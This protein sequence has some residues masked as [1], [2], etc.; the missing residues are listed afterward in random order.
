MTAPGYFKRLR[1]WTILALVALF[2]VALQP[3]Q[4]S[5]ITIGQIDN[6]EVHF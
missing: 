6:A 5:A 1:P 4:A 2:L 3:G